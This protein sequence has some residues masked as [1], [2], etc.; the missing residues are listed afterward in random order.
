MENEGGWFNRYVNS[1]PEKG[2]FK[3][4]STHVVLPYWVWRNPKPKLPGGPR[5][6]PQPSENLQRMMNLI[7]PLKDTSSIGRAKAALA[8]AQNVDEIFAGLDNVGTVHTARFL[9]LGNN[10]CMISVYDGDFSNYIREFIETVGSVLLGYPTTLENLRF[11]VLSPDALGLDGSFNAFR[12]LAQDA[13][14]FE[15][16]LSHAAKE[17][18]DHPHVDQLLAPGDEHRIGKGL[19]RCGA[20]RE[21]VAAQMCGRWRNGVS[22]EVSPDAQLP[23]PTSKTELTNFD[24]Y[25]PA[26]RRPVGSHLRRANPRGGTIVQRIANY[27]RRLV[28]RGMSYG[29]DF[30]P[31]NP[32]ARNGG[33]LGISP[34]RTWAHSSK[35][36]CATGSIWAFKIR[37]SPA[38]TIRCSVQIQLSQAGST[39]H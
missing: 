6:S 19:D 21:I 18:L 12:S 11:R 20:L 32:T 14:G 26:A 31:A 2:W 27:T 17:L 25:N 3:F 23:Y 36:P 1:L 13:A 7:M 29:P 35:R 38:P 5:T 24:H 15:A 8:I 28:R 39:C 33:Y 9:L 30:D 16:Y 22:V 37:T 4:L 10:I 34:V